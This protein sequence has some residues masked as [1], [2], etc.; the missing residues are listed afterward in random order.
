MEAFGVVVA[1]DQGDL[2]V[3]VAD[4]VDDGGE[5]FAEFGADDEEAFCVGLGRCDL[6]QGDSLTG[7]GQGVGDEAAVGEFGEFFDP[8]TER[9]QI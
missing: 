5:D 2:F 7:G 8:G 1:G 9:Q 6:Q 3:A 4:S